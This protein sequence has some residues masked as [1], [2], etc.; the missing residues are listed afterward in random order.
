MA[1]WTRSRLVPAAVLIV[2]AAMGVAHGRTVIRNLPRHHWE[3]W[4]FFRHNK[5]HIA[6]LADGFTQPSVWPGLYRPLSTNIYYYVGRRL[7]GTRVEAYHLVNAAVFAANAVLLFLVG[8][9][10]LPGAWSLLPPLLF[11][12]R[13]AHD[14]VLCFTSEFQALSSVFLTLVAT[15]LF[16]EGR[17]RESRR[18][19]LAAL[20]PFALALLCKE[21]S[22]VW[23]AILLAHARLLDRPGSWR[24]CLPA[25]AVAGGW[26]VLFVLARHVVGAGEP[27][28]FAYDASPALLGRVSAHLLTFSNLLAYTTSLDVPLPA[29]VELWSDTWVVR[30]GLAALLAVEARLLLWRP[31]SRA[32]AAAA[33]GF[34]WFLLGVAPFLFLEDRLFMRYGY[35]AHAGLALAVAGLLLAASSRRVRG[36][37][38]PAAE[39]PLRASPPRSR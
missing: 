6:S 22:V 21:T 38:P 25:L 30:V 12:S 34:A 18:L 1:L 9:R 17:A 3:D 19:E 16:L 4:R 10:W 20:A 2:L 8:R 37:T 11:A 39:A 32:L 15:L 27:T 14:Q 33:L 31:A 23:P 7:F 26:A 36:L 29:V 5:A 13:V 24:R 28:G 35:F